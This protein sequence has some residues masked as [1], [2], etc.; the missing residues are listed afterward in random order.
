MR[1]ALMF[2][3][4]LG[5]AAATAAGSAAAE[6]GCTVQ[7]F[8]APEGSVTATYCSGP[9]AQG[10]VTVTQTYAA[11][12]KSFARPLTIAIIAGAGA[13]RATDDIDLGPLGI[14]RTLHA[15]LSY[16]GGAARMTGGVLLPGAIPVTPADR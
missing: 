6:P 15:H 8:A 10:S 9:V 2:A 7:H 1:L 13:S 12:G 3:A 16:A 14:A 11:N 5:V 4:V